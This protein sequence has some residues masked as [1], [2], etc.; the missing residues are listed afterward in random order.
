MVVWQE[1]VL[2]FAS[3]F[4]LFEEGEMVKETSQVDLDT[5]QGWKAPC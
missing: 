4:P 2:E 5:R 3:V 1:L